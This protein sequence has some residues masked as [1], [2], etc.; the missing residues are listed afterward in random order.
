MVKQGLR[1]ISRRKA[2]GAIGMATAGAF[3]P[4]SVFG[5]GRCA[6]GYGTAACPLTEVEAIAPIKP[7]FAPTGWRTT[8]LEQ[9]TFQVPEYQKEAEFYSSLMGW[10]LRSDDGKRAVMDIGDWGSAIFQQSSVEKATVSSIGFVIDPWDT[11]VV[12]AELRKRGMDPVRERN[13]RGFVSFRVKDP[14]GFDLQICNDKGLSRARKSPADATLSI[15]LQLEP[16]GWKSIWLDH[17]SFG[18]TNYKESASFYSNLLGW[19]PTGDEGS[20]NL[21]A[22]GDVGDVVMRGGNPNDPKFDAA[23]PRHARIDHIS[24][25]IAPWDTDGVKAE[26]EKRG[27]KATLDTGTKGD[28]RYKSYHTITPNGYN[29]QMSNE[30]QATRLNSAHGL[31]PTRAAGA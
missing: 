1:T 7:I 2:L 3:F 5:Q 15:P 17:L 30:T 18:V 14:D 9:I 12:E 10:K 6:D 4:L 16:T 19:K 25:G 21:V 31:Y 20:L 27:L 22:I 24:F 26:L 11:K 29:L 13:E 28:D 8:A 23:A